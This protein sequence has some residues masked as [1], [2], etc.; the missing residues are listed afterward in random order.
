MIR[1]VEPRSASIAG[2]GQ[3][4]A[5]QIP[6]DRC[7]CQLNR[8]CESESLSYECRAHFW[9]LF[10]NPCAAGAPVTRK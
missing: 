2:N 1:L 9:V 3:A 7:G 4:E 8:W 5:S 6:V 10:Q